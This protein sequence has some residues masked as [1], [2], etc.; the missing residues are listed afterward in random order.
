MLQ[1]YLEMEVKTKGNE[2]HVTGKL[3]AS[4]EARKIDTRTVMLHLMDKGFS[5]TRI[6]IPDE[7]IPDVKEEG[8]WVFL[9]TESSLTKD[10]V[11]EYLDNYNNL[12]RFLS[13]QTD[14]TTPKKLKDRQKKLLGHLKEKIDE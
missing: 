11:V 9:S 1:D 10:S 5:L 12:G 3:R 13:S 6:I 2:V 7:V 4:D 8:E 14:E